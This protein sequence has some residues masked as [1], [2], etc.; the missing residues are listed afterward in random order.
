LSD[1]KPLGASTDIREGS[2]SFESGDFQIL[3]KDRF[4]PAQV[5]T[6]PVVHFVDG[7]PHPLGSCFV[8]SN[9]GLAITARHVIDE[10]FAEHFTIENPSVDIPPHHQLHAIY[11]STTMDPETGQFIGG[12]LPILRIWFNSGMDIAILQLDVPTNTQTGE[13]LFLP[14]LQL[15]PG[16]PKLGENIFGFGYHSMKWESTTEG[17][18]ADQ[19]FS[20]SRG[21]VQ[22]IHFPRRDSV[23][24]SFPCFQT[25]ARF[26]GGMSGGPIISQSGQVCG[27]ICSSMKTDVSDGTFTSYGSLIAPALALI[28]FGK[29]AS[30]IEREMFL[31]DFVVGGAVRVDETYKDIHVTNTGNEILVDLGGGQTFRNLIHSGQA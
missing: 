10:A 28:L 19:R 8:I 15:S 29:G 5:N 21:Q 11:A 31:H 17:F 14:A 18:Q 13:K 24:M 3:G 2:I 12:P 9:D 7:V 30:G 6:M 26:D 25:S 22:D 1:E 4:H 23:F 16:L 20:A 27:V